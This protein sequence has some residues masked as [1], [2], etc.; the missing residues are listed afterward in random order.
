MI[1]LFYKKTNYTLF[2]YFKGV[3][4]KKKENFG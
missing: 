1:E 3:A 2:I 4:G